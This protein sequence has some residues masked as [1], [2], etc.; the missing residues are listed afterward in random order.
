[1]SKY[2]TPK[3]NKGKAP[4]SIQKGSSKQKELAKNIWYVSY[5]YEG[6]QFKVKSNLNRIK[7]PN[8][9]ELQGEILLESIKK[10]IERGFN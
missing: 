5:T 3:L 7:D 10:E 1:M 2:T 8:E 4:I 9:K 6:K